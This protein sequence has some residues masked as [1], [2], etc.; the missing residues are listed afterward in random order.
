SIKTAVWHSDAARGPSTPSFDH[1][2]GAQQEGIRDRQAERLGGGQ[3]DDELESR[4]LLDRKFGRLRPAEKLV[5]IV[6]GAPELVQN[7]CS[8]RHQ[9]S[10]FDVV[11]IPVHRRQS[12][13]Q[14]RDADSDPGGYL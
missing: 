7:V 4:W 9:T 11:S 10:R 1:L 12:S 8:I 5:D 6:G 3:I 2:V 13:A 14:R